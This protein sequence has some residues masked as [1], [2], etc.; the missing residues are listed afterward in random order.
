VVM[1]TSRGEKKQVLGSKMKFAIVLLGAG[2]AAAAPK[3]E[4]EAARLLFPGTSIG[5]SVAVGRTVGVVGRT[6]AG[7][8][9]T[10]RCV[11]TPVKECVPRT[12]ETPRKVCQTVVDVFE[13]TTITERCEEVI[14]TTCTQTSEES[15]ITESI[16]STDTVKVEEGVPV[17]A[18]TLGRASGV[19]HRHIGKREADA[20][21]LHGTVATTLY[22]TR[23]SK[24]IKKVGHP[25]CVSTP[26]RQCENIPNA[27]K[28]NVARTV[29]DT[30]V[31]SHEVE[32]CT[33]T[34]TEVCE[35]T[36]T[37]SHTT[38]K[39]VGVSVL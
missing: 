29:C 11:R 13:D 17:D 32:D 31:D 6:V 33:E 22:N 38:G 5:G 15:H 4:P 16:A 30:V 37:Y 3:A 1:T 23:I 7:H 39:R 20:E 34:I 26:V 2:L 8:V 27:N 19:L 36:N 25:D 18:E 14:T 24:P 12:V 10:P 35:Q 21:A 9:S 28:R